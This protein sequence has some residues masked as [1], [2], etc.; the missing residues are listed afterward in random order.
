MDRTGLPPL[1]L[2]CSILTL[3]LRTSKEEE[4]VFGSDR[5]QFP[6]GGVVTVLHVQVLLPSTTGST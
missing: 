5:E 6:K 4:E 1:R 2:D 3:D